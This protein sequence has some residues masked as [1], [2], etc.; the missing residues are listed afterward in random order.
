MNATLSFSFAR[1]CGALGRDQRGLALIEFAVCA[2]VL[3]ILGMGGLETA[4]LAM[5]HFRISQMA[6]AV[7]DNSGRVRDSIDE[8]DVNEVLMGAKLS[9]NT[10]DF[11]KN[12]RVILS[13]LEKNAAGNGQWI[14]W[15]RCAGAKAVVS[16]YG[17]EGKGRIDNSLQAMGKV[18]N[19]I[20]AADGTAIMFVEV[21]YDYQPIV[22]T[23]LLGAN[24]ITYTAAFNVRKRTDQTLKNASALPD[25]QKSL[26]TRYTA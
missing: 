10:L 8:A 16:S 25:A 5:A 23:K 11:G 7:A 4:N 6:M 20:A 2:P 13:S 21:I 1:R 26:C 12:G 24:T 17:I 15:Q 9:A 14:R 22:S 3:L 18:G 19:Q